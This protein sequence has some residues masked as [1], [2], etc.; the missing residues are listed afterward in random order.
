MQMAPTALF[1]KPRQAIADDTPCHT[2]MDSIS[3]GGPR[4]EGE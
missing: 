1:Q 4:L 2:D 3:I